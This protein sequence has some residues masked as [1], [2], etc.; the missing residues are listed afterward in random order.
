MRVWTHPVPSL[1]RYRVAG[2]TS[3]AV[4]SMGWP[5]SQSAGAASR[6]RRAAREDF[7]PNGFGFDA[8]YETMSSDGT[9]CDLALRRQRIRSCRSGSPSP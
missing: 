6:M 3:L 2:S 8:D 9:L 5:T 4:S 1:P 7:I